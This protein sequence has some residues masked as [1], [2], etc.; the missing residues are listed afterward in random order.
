MT[1]RS[2]TFRTVMAVMAVSMASNV[3]AVAFVA[4][5][6]MCVRS[7]SPRTAIMCFILGMLTA[8]KPNVRIG[9]EPQEPPAAHGSAVAAQSN[10]S[11]GG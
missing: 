4:A 11:R 5:G 1:M 6:A 8:V 7:G 9:Q 2:G 10:K 3:V